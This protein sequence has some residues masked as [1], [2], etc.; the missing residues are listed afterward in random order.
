MFL[1]DSWWAVLSYLALDLEASALSQVEGLMSFAGFACQLDGLVSFDL[2]R[3]G[4]HQNSVKVVTVVYSLSSVI[5]FITIDN[6]GR[7]SSLKH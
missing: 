6:N 7:Q 1:V 4:I 3:N 5:Y 2:S